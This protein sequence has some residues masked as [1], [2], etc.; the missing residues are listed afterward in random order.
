MD[1]SHLQDR[2]YL[3][4]LVNYLKIPIY[5]RYEFKKFSYVGNYSSSFCWTI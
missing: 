1:L 2:Y 5:I 3:V 4:I